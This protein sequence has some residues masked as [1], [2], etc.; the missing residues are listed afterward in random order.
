MIIW[1]DVPVRI[2]QK[3]FHI[4]KI[5]G[6]LYNSFIDDWGDIPVKHYNEVTNKIEDIDNPRGLAYAAR[7]RLRHRKK[8]K[9]S[10]NGSNRES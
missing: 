6:R 3:I 4:R 7:K 8:Y 5:G 10:Q 1:K 9:R 2:R